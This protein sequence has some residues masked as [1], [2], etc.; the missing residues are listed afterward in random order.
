MPPAVGPDSAPN[1]A[2]VNPAPTGPGYGWNPGLVNASSSTG[3]RPITGS[4]TFGK[5]REPL[6]PATWGQWAVYLNNGL[7]AGRQD[8]LLEMQ[9]SGCPEQP[10]YA[11]M[12]EVVRHRRKEFQKQMAIGGAVA[13]AGLGIT[14]LTYNLASNGGSYF[15]LWGPVAFGAWYFLKGLWGWLNLPSR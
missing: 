3:A 11:L 13:V 7:K 12:A 10:S 8:L 5:P 6:S 15:V 4:Y 9:A 14:L 1:S 2:P